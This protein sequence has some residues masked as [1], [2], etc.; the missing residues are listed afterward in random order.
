MD[1]R[2]HEPLGERVVLGLIAAVMA[3]VGAVVV[4]A[5]DFWFWDIGWV[6]AES[7]PAYMQQVW[8]I[9]VAV[10]AVAFT[11]GLWKGS[12]AIDFAKSIWTD[13]W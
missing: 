8:F 9:P 2:R 11:I 3:G 10:A 4:E 13:Y 7:L 5:L 6:E 12:A 1:Q